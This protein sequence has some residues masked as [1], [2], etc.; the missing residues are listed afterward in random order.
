M[1]EAGASQDLRE[2]EWLKEA[3]AHQELDVADAQRAEFRDRMNAVL[4][5]NDREAM[6]KL[7]RAAAA[8]KR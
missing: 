4:Q 8:T 6:K 2:T 1:T 5:A 3:A 7:M